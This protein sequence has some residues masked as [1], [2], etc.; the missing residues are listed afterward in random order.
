MWPVNS[1]LNSDILQA[2]FFES[3][4]R[5]EKARFYSR[6]STQ[7]TVTEITNTFPSFGSV[8]EIRQFSG[9]SGGGTRQPVLL[10]DWSMTATVFEWEQT[11]P[12]TRLI[13]ESKSEAVRAK[14]QQIATKAMKGMDRV[15]C[16]A[17]N[18][19]TALGYDGVA[20]MSTAHPESGASQSNLVTGANITLPAMTAAEAEAELLA[21][22]PA[23]RAF[24]DDQGTPV[25]EGVS[26]YIVLCPLTFEIA[27]KLVADPTLSNQAIDSSGI[28]GRFR[29]QVE[30]IGSA[31]ATATGL[32]GGTVDRFWIFPVD[33]FGGSGSVAL[34]TLA[35]WQFNSNI[36]NENS[37]DWQN[38]MGYLRSWSAFVFAPWNWHSVMCRILT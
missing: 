17:L 33:D 6:L 34:A 29:G 14:T 11:V 28:T 30:V 35:D 25:N 12:I 16:Q 37:D 4:E 1:A 5:A 19:T 20:L 8:P 36:G 7:K 31:Y 23:L 26:R 2:D 9:I 3:V 21:G 27:M 13:A 15:F 24:V 18:S 10:K 38:G 22:I 32:P